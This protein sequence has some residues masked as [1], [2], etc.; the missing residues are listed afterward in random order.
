MICILRRGLVMSDKLTPQEAG[1]L[2]G[3]PVKQI[4][5]SQLKKLCAIQCTGEECASLL[6]IDYDTLNNRLKE[7]NHGG[8]SEFF[9]KHS[10]SGKASLRRRQYKAA[11]EDGNV[12]MMIWLGKQYLGQNDTQKLE[13]SNPDR[14]F[15]PTTIVLAAPNVNSND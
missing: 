2:G 11:V 14:T 1:L 9:K 10:A 3:A 8:F 15:T 7:D 6:D 4:D 12:P 5:Y 13:H